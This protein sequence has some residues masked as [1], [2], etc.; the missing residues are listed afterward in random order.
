MSAVLV[1][2]D[3]ALGKPPALAERLAP[4]LAPHKLP[5]RVLVTS[6]LPLTASGKVDRKACARR[7]TAAHADKTL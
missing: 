6:S 5:R 1:T 2:R 3:A 4:H 7:L